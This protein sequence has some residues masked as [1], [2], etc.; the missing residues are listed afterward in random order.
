MRAAEGVTAATGSGEP[1][2]VHTDYD[3]GALNAGVN[4]KTGLAFGLATTTTT[5]VPAEVSSPGS[6]EGLVDYTAAIDPATIP[7]GKTPAAGNETGRA[8][9]SYD[10]WG[11]VTGYTDATGT[12]TATSYVAAGLPG[13]GQVATI[14]DPQSTTSYS[15]DETSG[16]R[17]EHRGLVTT[18]TV[19]GATT[20][21]PLTYRASYDAAGD[22][23]SQALPAGITQT[24]AYSRDGQQTALSYEGTA[25]DGTSTPL[26]GWGLT[27]DALGRTTAVS[28]NAGT[29]QD[30]IGRT[31]AYGYDHASRL[32]SVTDARGDLCQAHT[33]VFDADSNRTGQ[34]TTTSPT[35]DCADSPDT[36]LEKTWAYDAADR[37]QHGATSTTTTV[38]G[39]DEAGDPV[40]TTD[41]SGGGAYGYDALDRVATLPAT[42]TPTSTS[43]G[44]GGGG[45]VAVGYYDTD[46]AHTLT[47]DG[48]RT[49]YTLDPAGRRSDS[50]TTKTG[51]NT[52]ATTRHYGDDTDNPSF[53]TQTT[54]TGGPVVSI[55]G[56]SIG[57]DL[58]VTITDGV[59][60][61]A[62]A[63]PHGDTI[64][65]LDL[66]TNGTAPQLSSPV[67]CFDEYG[68]P[69][70]DLNQI[71]ADTE[72][73]PIDPTGLQLMGARLY[74]P[75]T[76]RFTSIDP[77]EGG[78]PN[79]Y[80]YPVDPINQTDLNGQW[81]GWRKTLKRVATATGVLAAGACIVATAGACIAAT[82]FAI[83]A[84]GAWNTYRA[85]HH[86]ISAK[87]A[88]GNVLVDS[89][90]TLFRPVR[91]FRYRK[92]VPRHSAQYF[93]RHNSYG[94]RSL[95]W[96]ARNHRRHT[97]VWTGVNAYYG[98]RSYQSG[99]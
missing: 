10:A 3:Q 94:T 18:Q 27:A 85:R 29:G 42:D 6:G 56:T 70:T 58:A 5:Q 21:G 64:T 86:E 68:N 57:G 52:I 30:A 71:Q 32:T 4:P 74:N 37:V 8:S 89:A 38:T 20:G 83:G 77:I 62:L 26:L 97:A 48:T 9:T 65:T 15:Y 46:T 2:R 75:A 93:G 88:I 34:T 35:G 13:A 96:V 24:I 92:Y 7:A 45:D 40:S 73:N 28:T 54:G 12:H 87:R 14:S 63:D 19:T 66:P 91:Y 50:T 25:A 95:R 69:A 31:L 82:T 11:K 43:A 47:Q 44:A 67:L 81:W 80:A 99:W 41:T 39:T 61:V 51:T 98:Y 55:Y 36:T 72:G 22:L 79:A 78:S 59:A 90:P 17:A 76:G 1:V 53:A 84:S 33:Y 23:V 60:S 16:G 49:T